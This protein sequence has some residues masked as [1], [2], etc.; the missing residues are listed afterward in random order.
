MTDNK[1]IVEKL[2]KLLEFLKTDDKALVYTSTKKYAKRRFE[3][4]NSDVDRA[5]ELL[6]KIK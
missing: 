1:E 3:A 5:I 6:N 4:I 2:K